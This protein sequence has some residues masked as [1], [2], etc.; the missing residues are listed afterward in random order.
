MADVLIV[1][2][3]DDIIKELF[4]STLK[5]YQSGLEESMRSSEFVYDCVN[6]LHKVDLNRGKSYINSPIWLK[7]KKA[8][9]NPKNM[10]DDFCFQYAITVALNY[11]KIKN[12]PER[13][14][15]IK[16]F[17]DQY[18]W[19][20]IYFPSYK[21]DWNLFE[22]NNKSVALNVLH[23]PH[24]TK[25]IRHAYKSKYN[26]SREDQVILLMITDGKKWHYLAV[27]SVSALLRGIT[28]NNHDDIC[29]LNSLHSYTTENKLKKY[30]EICENHRY[31][32]LEMPKEGDV[33]ECKS[34][35]KS[36]MIPFAIYADLESIL[37]KIS[38]C[39]DDPEKPPTAKINKHTTSGY[40]LFSHCLFD[41]T[42]NKCDYY[43]GVNCM[44]NFSLDLRYH[45]E[46]II[47]Y[48]QGE[49]IP[50]TKEQ[51]RA[52]R[53]QKLCYIC[54]KKFSTDDDNKKYHKIKDHC[55]YT[56]KYRGAA[57]VMYSKKFKIQK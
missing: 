4:E 20:G 49:I 34:G 55:Y 36:I 51:R 16:P 5:R 1:N 54:D 22:K 23:V 39:E 33:I 3:T 13:I 18:D 29:C 19:S 41:K 9:I 43:R 26:L 17:I 27:K 6:E 53:K 28:G 46:K 10:K 31:C 8:T 47:S 45:T 40:L 35:E 7:N 25:R 38:S 37:K 32:K 44:R 56:G 42:K 12:H 50:L 24:N 30:R 52:H 15:N 21:T 57:H 11:G 2:T 48:E 14:K